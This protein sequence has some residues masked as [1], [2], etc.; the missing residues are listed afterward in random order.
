MKTLIRWIK[1]RWT[2]F[3]K[4]IGGFGNPR[5]PFDLKTHADGR[6]R[7]LAL[8]QTVEFAFRRRYSLPPSDP[9]FLDATLEDMVLDYWAHAHVDNPKLRDEVVAEGYDDDLAEMQREV[10]EKAAQKAASSTSDGDWETVADDT[11]S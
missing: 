5:P 8:S 7:G 11:F 2:G 9:R 10:D 6:D 4:C 1:R 3:L